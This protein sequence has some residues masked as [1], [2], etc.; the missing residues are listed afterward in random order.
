MVFPNRSI[1]RTTGNPTTTCR[2]FWARIEIETDRDISDDL[3]AA[4]W[5]ALMPGMKIVQHAGCFEVRSDDGSIVR[6]F[7]FDGNASRRAINGKMNKKQ[8]LRAAKT[9]AGKGHTIV[10]TRVSE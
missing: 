9:F 3:P 4:A 5:R 7:A 10:A 6:R 1:F 2:F 8:A